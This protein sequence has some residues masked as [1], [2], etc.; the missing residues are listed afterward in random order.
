MMDKD[1][2]IRPSMLQVLA[3]KGGTVALLVAS[4]IFLGYDDALVMK[5]CLAAMLFCM[6]SLLCSLWYF[7]TVTW[8]VSDT[9]I[10]YVRGIAGKATDYMELY[11][12]IDYMERQSFLQQLFGLKDV[13]IISGDRTHPMLIMYG[14]PAH[15]NVIDS[16]SEK[17]EQCKKERNVYEITNR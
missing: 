11:R 2:L 6:L 15:L 14:L 12:V 4:V 8:S 3:D 10:K 13:V 9:R 7:S 1:N 5:C 16:I 17:V